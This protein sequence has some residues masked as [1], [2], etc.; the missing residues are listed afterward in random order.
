VGSVDPSL[1]AVGSIVFALSMLSLIG[2]ELL[3]FPILLSQY[4]SSE[5]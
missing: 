4:G 3:L 5:E 2:V 1:N